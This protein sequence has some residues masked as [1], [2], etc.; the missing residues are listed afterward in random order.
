MKNIFL[1][2]LLIA[3]S[4]FVSCKKDKD[5]P[6]PTDIT[7]L[8]GSIKAQVNPNDAAASMRVE[9]GNTASEQSGSPAGSFLIENLAPGTYTV[10]F[11]A[12]PGYMAPPRQTVTV[13]AG[14]ITDLGTVSLAKIVNTGAIGA[15]INGSN[16]SAPVP[17]GISDSTGVFVITAIKPSNVPGNTESIILA[18]PGLNGTGTY[19]SPGAVATYS[20][21]VF[22]MALPPVLETKVWDTM[23]GLCTVTVSKF[24]TVNKVASGTFSFVARPSAQV[25]NNT[26]TGTK[27]ITNGVFT[28]VGFAIQ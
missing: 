10:T 18:I 5:D 13:T 24:D 4:I 11:S 26:A 6:K 23:T 14:N 3:G 28:D 22:T 19:T 1:L 17:Y 12:M 2:C 7:T 16:W 27:T 8:T 15:S 20:Q 25:Q 9:M 21:T